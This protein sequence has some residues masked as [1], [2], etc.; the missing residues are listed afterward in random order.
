MQDFVRAAIGKEFRQNFKIIVCAQILPRITFCLNT[1]YILTKLCPHNV[2][3]SKEMMILHAFLG[4]MKA[5]FGESQIRG[6]IFLTA[7]D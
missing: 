5:G 1:A 4:R 3:P 2:Y 6:R 7:A